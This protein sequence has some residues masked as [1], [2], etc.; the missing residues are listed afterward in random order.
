MNSSY[1]LIVVIALVLGMAAYAATRDREQSP[2][3]ETAMATEITPGQAPQNSAEAEAGA[4]VQETDRAGGGATQ[5]QDQGP[6]EGAIDEVQEGLKALGEAAEEPASKVWEG[7]K[8]VAGTVED[9]FI[10]DETQSAERS[11]GGQ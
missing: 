3:V 8:D 11:G 10:G 5:A 9:V 6:I 1:T 4:S 2:A 7:V